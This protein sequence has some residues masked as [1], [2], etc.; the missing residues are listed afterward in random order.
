LLEVILIYKV[1][2]ESLLLLEGN[3][4]NEVVEDKVPVF[5]RLVSVIVFG[6]HMQDKLEAGPG[7]GDCEEL[8]KRYL[9]FECFAGNVVDILICDDEHSFLLAIALIDLAHVASYQ[10]DLGRR[11]LLL[12][13]LLSRNLHLFGNLQSALFE[14]IL[15]LVLHFI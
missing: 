3:G 9:A 8:A 10:D 15:D 13:L 1:A 12:E 6:R 7:N 14:P 2:F 5:W 4:G 11:C